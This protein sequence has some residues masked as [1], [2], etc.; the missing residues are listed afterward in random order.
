MKKF[1]L[2]VLIVALLAPG[3]AAEKI[4]PTAANHFMG[5]RLAL[6]K[7]DYNKALEEINS[8]I[9]L[10]PN[11]SPS[12]CSSSSGASSI[13]PARNTTGPRRTSPR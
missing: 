13:W 5:A 7:N 11:Y 8:A 2:V 1:I 6:L 4:S 12:T 9:A 10:S 3:A